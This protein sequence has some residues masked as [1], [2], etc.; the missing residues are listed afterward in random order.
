MSTK[1][2]DPKIDEILA[3]AAKINVC[4]AEIHGYPTEITD[5]I[6]R[7]QVSRSSSDLVEIT[8]EDIIECLDGECGERS[9]FFISDDSRLR[10]I[11]VRDVSVRE[12][13][14]ARAVYL[15]QKDDSDDGTDTSCIDVC[16]DNLRACGKQLPVDSCILFWFDCNDRCAS[17]LAFGGFDIAA[18]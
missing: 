11:R 6:I 8:R 3:K 2:T 13:K 12:A 10:L 17:N 9:K 14:D 5:T 18:L 16:D 1:N 7:I 15:R 4:V